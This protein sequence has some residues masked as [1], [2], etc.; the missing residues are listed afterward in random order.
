MMS[1]KAASWNIG[2]GIL[3]ESH[4]TTGTPKLDHHASVIDDCQP[5]VLCLQEAHVYSSGE[6]QVAT[7]AR[8]CGYKFHTT[9][10][11][12][13]SHL[14]E[15]A[16]LALGLLS[17]FPVISQDYT[18]FPNPDLRNTGPNGDEWIL[19]DK[20]LTVA[21][22]DLGQASLRVINA[23]HFPFHYFNADA[24]DPDLAYV[25]APLS[26]ALRQCAD[27]NSL[28]CIDLNSPH[29]D[30][31][32]ADELPLYQE[33]MKRQST[34]PKGVQQDYI[35]GSRSLE[36]EAHIQ[37]VKSEADHYLCLAKLRVPQ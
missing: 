18:E 33:L 37:A 32:L 2:G 7:L 24:R 1:V 28:A 20:G 15:G 30:E 11:I 3:G 10:R 22:L 14:A 36:L 16:D 21:K 13:P 35:L 23:H 8:M 12:S 17:K 25:L 31:L 27:E 26:T 6:D 29:I 5:D 4:Q 19:F 34:T 9:Q